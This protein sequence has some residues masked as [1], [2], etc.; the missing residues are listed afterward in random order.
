MAPTPTPGT[1][2]NNLAAA[3]IFVGANIW[4]FAP[5][6]WYQQQQQQGYRPAFMA[7]T[8]PQHQQHQQQHLGKYPILVAARGLLLS[9]LIYW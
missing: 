8:P 5:L 3:T 6:F 7:P 4:V 9:C 2:T 1:N